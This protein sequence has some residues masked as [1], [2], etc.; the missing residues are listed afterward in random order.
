MHHDQMRRIWEFFCILYQLVTGDAA[1]NTFI[2]IKH[3]Q[4]KSQAVDASNSCLQFWN[5][6]KFVNMIM[7]L[8]YTDNSKM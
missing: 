4:V 8:P 7:K 3:G 1:D 2:E 5:F 6:C